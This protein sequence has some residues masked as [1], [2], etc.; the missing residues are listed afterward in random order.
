MHPSLAA[1]SAGRNFGALGARRAQMRFNETLAL[2]EIKAPL[3]SNN[4]KVF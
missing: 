4:E 3:W 1:C 2:A